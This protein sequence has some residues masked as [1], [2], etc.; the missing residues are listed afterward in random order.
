MIEVRF[1]PFTTWPQAE[2]RD[3]AR[4]LFSA[5]WSSTLNL[6]DVELRALEAEDVVIETGHAQRDIRND[7][8]PRSDARVP[9]MPGVILSFGSKHGPLRYL[10]DAFCQG[11]YQRGSQE[12]GGSW[13]PGW[14]ANLRAI[15]LGLEALRAVD[16]YGVS[17]RG[18]QYRGWNELPSGIPMGEASM[19]IEEAAS[20]LEGLA[21]MTPRPLADWTPDWEKTLYRLASKATHPDLNGGDQA[22][23]QRV[24][25]AHQILKDYVR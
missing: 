24:E 8:W 23:F 9:P 16:R 14:Q 5:S 2:T 19:T 22:A 12:A 13:M 25:R 21:E 11:G 4:G 1:R 20:L 17:K 7:G 10:T 18:E 15:A 6:L 3:R